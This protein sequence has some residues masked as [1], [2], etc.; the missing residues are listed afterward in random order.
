MELAKKVGP[1]AMR[2]A[3]KQMEKVN[4][5]ANAEVKKVVDE[6]RKRLEGG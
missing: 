3:E 4:E 2:R 6:A 5:K 1:D